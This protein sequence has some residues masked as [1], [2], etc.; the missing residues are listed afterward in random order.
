[1]RFAH[2]CVNVERCA[3][4]EPRPSTTPHNQGVG[5]RQRWF[6]SQNRLFRPRALQAGAGAAPSGTLGPVSSTEFDLSCAELRT[7]VTCESATIRRSNGSLPVGLL[8]LA[9]AR[10]RSSHEAPPITCNAA[11]RSLTGHTLGTRRC[12]VGPPVPCT[13]PHRPATSARHRRMIVLRV[14]LRQLL[15]VTTGKGRIS[16]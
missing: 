11:Y 12:A 1:M 2:G 6:K 13:A 4:G 16:V 15:R 10:T 3:A 5:V 9:L 14:E 7:S 8:S